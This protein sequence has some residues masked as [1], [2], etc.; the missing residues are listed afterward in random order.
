MADQEYELTLAG[1]TA[2]SDTDYSITLKS[3]TG[4][5]EQY[6]FSIQEAKLTTVSY[7][8]NYARKYGFYGDQ[9]PLFRAVLAFH[10]ARRI[11]FAM[12]PD[13]SDEPEEGRDA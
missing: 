7:D 8:D 11:I 13:A 12:P 9:R 4:K 5:T 6:A 3:R 10:E 2:T 1:I